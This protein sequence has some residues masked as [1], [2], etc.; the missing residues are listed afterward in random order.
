VLQ[1]QLESGQITSQQFFAAVQHLRVRN[2]DGTW[3]QIRPEDGSWLCWNGESWDRAVPT[4]LQGPQTLVDF[5]FDILKDCFKGLLWKLPISIGAALVVWAI[6]TVLI[7]S[8]NDGLVAGQ[9]AVLD[10]LLSLPG[11]LA[12]GIIFWSMLACLAAVILRRTIKQGFNLIMQRIMTAPAWI[13]YA[14]S[15]SDGNSLIML[16]SGCASA[17]LLGVLLGN[18]LVSFLWII[19]ALGAL[20]SQDKSLVL[21]AFRLM[22]SDSLRLLNRHP[23]PFNPAW[24]GLILIGAVF[25]F[26]SAV[27][28]PLM[29]YTGCAGVILLAGGIGLLV[30]LRQGN[31]SLAAVL[32]LMI[33]WS[34][35]PPLT[36]AGQITVSELGVVIAFGILPALGA[37]VGS[38]VGLSL[39]GWKIRDSQREPGAAVPASRMIRT[40]VDAAPAPASAAALSQAHSLPS[41]AEPVILKGQPAMDVLVRLGMIRRVITPQGGRYLPVDLNPQG[42]VSAIAYFIDEQGY[43]NSQ[44]A[45][46]YS[47]PIPAAEYDGVEQEALDDLASAEASQAPLS[48]EEP[49]PEAPSAEMLDQQDGEP[50]R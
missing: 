29:P 19:V 3:W 11:Q 23:K 4:H 45:I 31:R 7:V 22:W 38:L 32:L 27:I 9:N 20:V 26:M 24:G 41:S 30:L 8:L 15:R 28:L 36:H 47:P 5:I 33:P 1:R 14:L 16:L 37:F 2:E 49:H 17:L 18:R 50:D 48:P 35:L 39:G 13:E 46:A 10:M 44:F 42:P 40:E 25:G 43:L 21:W 6:H 12:P 34:A